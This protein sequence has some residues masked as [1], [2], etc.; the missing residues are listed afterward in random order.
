MPLDLLTSCT[1]LSYDGLNSVAVDDLQTLRGNGQ[2]DGTALGGQVEPALL[3]VGVPT[4]RVAAVRVGDGLAELWLPSRDLA[5]CR[6]GLTSFSSAAHALITE[7][8]DTEM[9]SEGPRQS[10]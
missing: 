5:M 8:L 3:Y 1:D 9:R 10:I 6:H 4:T 2:S 7:K